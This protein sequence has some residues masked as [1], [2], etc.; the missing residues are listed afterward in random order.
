MPPLKE[1]FQILWKE[2]EE[3]KKTYEKT[4]EL[5]QKQNE[6]LLK[7]NQVWNEYSNPFAFK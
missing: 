4:V 3:A 2:K 6:K 5:L 7:E 1:L